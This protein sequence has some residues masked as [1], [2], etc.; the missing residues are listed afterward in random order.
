MQPNSVSWMIFARLMKNRCF[1]K[2]GYSL[3]GRT[4]QNSEFTPLIGQYSASLRMM[5]ALVF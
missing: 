4:N 1:D 3:G 2:S 5:R